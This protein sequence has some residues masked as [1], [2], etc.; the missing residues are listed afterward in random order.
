MPHIPSSASTGQSDASSLG[1]GRV[2]MQK[3]WV[4]LHQN[5]P[6][7][8]SHRLPARSAI[9]LVKVSLHHEDGDLEARSDDEVPQSMRDE[10]KE[11]P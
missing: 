5:Q 10:G 3:G 7:R 9:G 2:G 6:V 1:L 11:V 4:Y 8:K